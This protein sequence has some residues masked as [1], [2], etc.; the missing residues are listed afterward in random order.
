[1]AGP[2]LA[3]SI[4]HFIKSKFSKMKIFSPCLNCSGIMTNGKKI[5]VQVAPRVQYFKC[6]LTFQLL[7]I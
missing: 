1:M 6:I 3:Y 4:V 5:V 7:G 2:L